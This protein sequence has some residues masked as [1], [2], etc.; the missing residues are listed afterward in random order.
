[1]IFNFLI[2]FILW[3]V[4]KSMKV[5][6]HLFLLYVVLYSAIR[7]FVEHFR[8]DQLTVFGNVSAVQ[9][10]GV[11]ETIL[12]FFLMPILKRKKFLKRTL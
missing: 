10:M 5:D 12:G 1:M 4:R 3:K 2:F 7:V 9:I 6:G 8:A 11:M